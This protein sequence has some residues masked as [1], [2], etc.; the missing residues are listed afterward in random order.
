MLQAIGAMPTGLNV[1]S[2]RS[3]CHLAPMTSG[4][5]GLAGAIFRWWRKL[6]AGADMGNADQSI[7]GALAAERGDGDRGDSRTGGRGER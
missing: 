7:G 3:M 1:T 5:R 4:S 6:W 2:D